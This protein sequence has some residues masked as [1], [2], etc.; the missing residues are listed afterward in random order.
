MLQ[1][2]EGNPSLPQFYERREKGMSTSDIYDNMMR[3]YYFNNYDPRREEGYGW[4]NNRRRRI[5]YDRELRNRR[6]GGIPGENEE[7]NLPN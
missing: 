7:E 1:T 6:R 3:H 5:E 2:P 4:Y